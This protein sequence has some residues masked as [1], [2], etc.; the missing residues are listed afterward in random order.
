MPT[1]RDS[2]EQLI[3]ES[4]RL[5]IES[6]QVVDCGR[7]RIEEAKELIRQVRERIDRCKASRSAHI[8]NPI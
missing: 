2:R 6:Q 1:T 5:L 8:A 7:I 4:T 3:E